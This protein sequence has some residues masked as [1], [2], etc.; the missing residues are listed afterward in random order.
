LLSIAYILNFNPTIVV[1]FIVTQSAE[2]AH[3]VGCGCVYYGWS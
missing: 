3:T 2:N 1:V